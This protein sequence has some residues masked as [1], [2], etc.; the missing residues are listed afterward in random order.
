[1]DI[2][3]AMNNAYSGLQIQQQRFDRGVS[4][5]ASAEALN[6]RDTRTQDRALVEQQEIASSFQANARS[7]EAAG[8]RIGTIIDIK[9]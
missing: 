8:E 6:G 4:Q 9:V 7:L 2:S 5:V 3:S 1:M